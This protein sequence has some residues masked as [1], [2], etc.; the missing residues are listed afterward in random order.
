MRRFITTIIVLVVIIGAGWFGYQRLIASQAAAAN[1]PAYETVAVSRGSINSTVSA[2]GSIEP[3][4][5]VALSFRTAG[6]VAQ[7]L[8][9]VG[10]SVEAGQLLAQLDISDLELALEQAQVSLQISQ[11]Q[12]K[13]LETP[14]SENDL[15]AAQAAV[16]VAQASVASAEA[17]LSSAQAG[18]RQLLTGPSAEELAVQESQVR[19]AEANVRQAQQAYD[20][21]RGMPNVGA[22]PQAAQL[23]QATIAYEVARAQF[24]VSQ[25]PATEAQIAS[26]L[27]QI[28]QAELSV[29]QARSNLLTA[30]N[31]LD[32]LIK[33]PAE[34]DLEIARAQV[35]QAELNKI[36]SERSKDNA[37]IFAPFT[38]VVSQVNTRQGELYSGGMPALVLTDL[39]R[40][41][42]TVLVDELD[43]RQVQVGQTV[44]L[45]L[46]AL[47]DADITGEVVSISP[48]ASNVGGVVAYDVD[49]VPNQ[50]EAQLRA[51]MSATAIITTAEVDNVLLIPNRYIQL[52]RESGRAFVQKMAGGSP[53]LQEI[54]MGLRNDRFSQVIAGLT[55]A[56]TIALI[57]TTS[58]DRLR[59]A[60]FGGN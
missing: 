33:G 23:E 12:L 52:D 18:Y 21:V 3:E 10:Q 6:R 38:G 54:E 30:Q 4:A 16:T 55:D 17:G 40:F 43:V 28:A 20:Q 11:A 26:A 31:N 25:K 42:M 36:Q 27:S 41:H 32:T 44:R 19:Q 46:D 51:G 37:R 53:V 48:T 50:S 35:R 13:K 59:G 47:P 7:V 34:E 49:I 9:S 2:T 5:Q 8:V 39:N 56:D 1:A 45:S 57:R 15:A 29:R 24:T 60:I 58:E 14:P 22:L